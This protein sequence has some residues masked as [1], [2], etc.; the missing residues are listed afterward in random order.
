MTIRLKAA[1]ISGLL[2]SSLA[3][4]NFVTPTPS[5]IPYTLHV[6]LIGQL[7]KNW[8]WAACMEMATTYYHTTIDST[9][10]AV[11][12]CAEVAAVYGTKC[13]INCD[14]LP[15]VIPSQY[16]QPNT[17]FT[18]P[19]GYQFSYAPNALSWETLVAEITAK[20][21]VIF[22][23]YWLGITQA[24][25]E[26]AGAH[27]LIAEGC[28]QTNY[29]KRSGWISVHDPLPIGKGHHR[30]ITYNAYSGNRPVSLNKSQRYIYNWFGGGYYQI[31]H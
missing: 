2:L 9:A 21:P 16:D 17:P 14:S 22:K 27:F 11:K 5:H 28:P 1:A 4:S 13:T 8:C 31:K 25:E 6:P 7:G 19:F 20:R 3:L 30:I 18:K 24:T 12:Q 23:W 26:S 10:P 29:I 15:A